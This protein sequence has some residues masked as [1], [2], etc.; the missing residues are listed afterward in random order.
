MAV[1]ERLLSLLDSNNLKGKTRI[2]IAFTMGIA[3][4]I[5]E[6][7]IPDSFTV[8]GV[9]ATDGYHRGPDIELT[10]ASRVGTDRSKR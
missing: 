8:G 6:H 2:E 3:R 9:P 10:G 7:E 5:V 4:E 1:R